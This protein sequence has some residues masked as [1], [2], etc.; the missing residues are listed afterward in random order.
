MSR[1]K[2][3][4]G[5]AM[6]DKLRAY[7]VLVDGQGVG[8]IR[9]GGKLSVPVTPGVH[10]VQFKIDWCASPQLLVDVAADATEQVSCGPRFDP[11]M[12]LLAISVFRGKYLF[13]RLDPRRPA[14]AVGA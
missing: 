1:I 14:T 11:F 5:H 6:G 2:I 4:R 8:E 10:T 12:A 9:E 3:V 13:A 7:R